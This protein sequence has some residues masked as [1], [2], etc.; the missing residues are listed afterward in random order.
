METRD[1]EML[2][3]RSNDV[4]AACSSESM[5]EAGCTLE[6]MDD[7]CD[8]G[9]GGDLAYEFSGVIKPFCQAMV[10][11]CGFPAKAITS[12]SGAQCERGQLRAYG[13]EVGSAGVP[14]RYWGLYR[15]CL[16]RKGARTP[17]SGR[18]VSGAGF[19]V[20]CRNLVQGDGRYWANELSVAIEGP[21]LDAGGTTT[22]HPGWCNGGG[23]CCCCSTI[24][25]NP[26][27]A[28]DTGLVMTVDQKV[29][30]FSP[31]LLI[32]CHQLFASAEKRLDR[33]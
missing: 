14:A 30:G 26:A 12:A 27:A 20:L 21:T 7:A 28:T 33:V 2:L 25:S 19:I 29:T 10:Q 13:M 15:C 31:R 3:C 23:G 1:G 16:G 11:N 4:V 22:G 24:G 9:W 17:R 18:S 5:A 6:V 32:D 8:V